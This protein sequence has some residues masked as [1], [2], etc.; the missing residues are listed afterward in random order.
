MKRRGEVLPFPVPLP[1]SCFFF[2]GTRPSVYASILLH[3]ADSL[4]F[5]VLVEND[6]IFIHIHSLNAFRIAQSAPN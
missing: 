5:L 6:G 1:C 2:C 4:I 3:T